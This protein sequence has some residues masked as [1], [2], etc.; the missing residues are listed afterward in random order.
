MQKAK[1]LQKKIQ[2]DK[3]CK[4]CNT[5]RYGIGEN[6]QTGKFQ[7]TVWTGETSVTKRDR[8]RKKRRE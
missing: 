3:K 6:Y 5:T 8:E 7:V 2:N 1:T 4:K